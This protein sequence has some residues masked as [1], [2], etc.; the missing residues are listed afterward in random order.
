MDDL[1]DSALWKVVTDDTLLSVNYAQ[2]LRD[3]KNRD[4]DTVHNQ[5]NV[6][7]SS[8]STQYVLC[9]PYVANSLDLHIYLHQLQYSHITSPEVAA[10]KLTTV[11]DTERKITITILAIHVINNHYNNLS[12]EDNVIDTILCV[13][14]I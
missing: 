13:H 7:L 8:K 9:I 10:A 2:P 11:Q 5:S 1:D 12:D 14:N 6:M 3:I 4:F